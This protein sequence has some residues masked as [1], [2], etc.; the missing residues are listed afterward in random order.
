MPRILYT[1]PGGTIVLP[2]KV[3]CDR[4]SGGHL[5]V[6]PSQEVWERSELSPV[7]LVQWS[8]L[9]AATGRAMLNALPALV[10]GCLNY[11]EAGNWALNDRANPEGPKRVQT[12]RRV[13]MHIFGRSRKSTDSDWRWGESP[14]FPDFAESDV[15]ASRLRPLTDDECTKVVNEANSILSGYYGV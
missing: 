8:Y 11:W 13:H 12:H 5:I 4:A 14:R 6:N 1:G 7:D 9:V 15:W 2:D 10:D 3:L